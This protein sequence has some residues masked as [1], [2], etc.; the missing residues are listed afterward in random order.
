MGAGPKNRVLPNDQLLLRRTRCLCRN[1]RRSTHTFENTTE[2]AVGGN[3]RSGVMLEGGACYLET[4]Q[5]QVEVLCVGSAVGAG[6]NTRGF[7]VSLAFDLQRVA[8]GT[9]NNRRHFAFLLSA[10][11]GRLAMALGTESSCD[12]VALARHPLNNFL[13]YRRIILTAL[14]PLIE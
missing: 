12:L 3:D 8:V 1:Q 2:I 10:D 5:E 7:R 9:G 4:P 14:K 6:V 11:V 13:S